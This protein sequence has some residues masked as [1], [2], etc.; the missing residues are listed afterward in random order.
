MDCIQTNLVYLLPP[1]MSLLAVIVV[2]F[3]A[4]D[5]SLQREDE[6]KRKKNETDRINRL[7]TISLADLEKVK[8][9][10]HFTTVDSQRFAL[11]QC[12]M[13]DALISTLNQC[14]SISMDR[15]FPAECLLSMFALLY[16]TYNCVDILRL[17]TSRFFPK[18][19]TTVS[20]ICFI[21]Y[22][23]IV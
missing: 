9:N 21:R 14:L 18:T 13:F 5:F 19:S 20:L 3:I 22:L 2:V 7:K 4:V 23:T 1:F 8:D 10:V 11:M 16:H 17:H 15:L 6:E 12:E